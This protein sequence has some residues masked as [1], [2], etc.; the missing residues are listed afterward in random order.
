MKLIKSV[1]KFG[2][3]HLKYSD[4][5]NIYGEDEFSKV[6]AVS[7][8]T[9]LYKCADDLDCFDICRDIIKIPD[10]NCAI[11]N[12]QLIVVVSQHLAGILPPP[13]SEI[14]SDF[15]LNN[16]LVINVNSGCSGFVEA[17]LIVDRFFQTPGYDN[18]IILCADNYSKYS[19]VE[20]R[21]VSSIFS[22]AASAVVVSKS[23]NKIISSNYGTLSTRSNNLKYKEFEGIKMNGPEI[24]QFVK[25]T[26]LPSVNELC[27][28][29]DRK[30]DI[31]LVHQGSKLVIDTFR[32][33]L[34]ISA[35]KCPFI[36]S[37]SGNI[38]ASTIPFL[39]QNKESELVNKR[40]LL[41]GFGVGLSYCNLVLD[42]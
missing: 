34:G 30:P 20:N 32:K 3:V 38:N 25:N 31:F 4:L 18:A 5:A 28:N 33:E 17:L 1:V 26:V 40:C 36:I 27:L 24:V 22:D 2:D 23:N 16:K 42:T 35:D 9:E 12:S 10:I 29:L 13:A 14:F 15:D 41:S 19:M 8:I 39:L 6:S 7:G 37:Q 11:N 21:S